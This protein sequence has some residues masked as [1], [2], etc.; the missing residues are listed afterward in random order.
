MAAVK[1][2]ARTYREETRRRDILIN[3]ACP[4][5]VNT[6][7]SRPFF[8]DMSEAQSPEE[9]A[10]DVLWLATLPRGTGEPYGELV[11]HRTVLP[12][13][14]TPLTPQNRTDG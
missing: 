12:F 8:A 4:G 2:M 1:V 7:A 13:H 6:D 3:A 14:G 10:V 11:Q 9:A 5:L